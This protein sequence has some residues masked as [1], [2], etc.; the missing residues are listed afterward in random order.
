MGLPETLTV[1]HM[2]PEQGLFQEGTVDDTN[3]V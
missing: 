3:L 2:K 1:A